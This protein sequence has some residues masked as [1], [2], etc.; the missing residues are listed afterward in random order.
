MAQHKSATKRARQDLRRRAHN[1][2]IR[3]GLRSA[4][5]D[6]RDAIAA[7]EPDHA[8]TTLR[9]TEGIIRRAASKGILPRARANRTISRLSRALHGLS[10]T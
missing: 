8:R 3:S 7:G 2:S 10:D 6:T 4:V 5:K 1:R 9:A